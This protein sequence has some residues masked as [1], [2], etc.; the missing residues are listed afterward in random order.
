MDALRAI[1]RLHARFPNVTGIEFDVDVKAL[2][3]DETP[4]EPDAL[5][6]E[7]ICTD[8]CFLALTELDLSKAYNLSFPSIL[9]LVQCS[10]LESLW[11]PQ[12]SGWSEDELR[13]LQRLPHLRH[14]TTGDRARA[15]PTYVEAVACLTNLTSFTWRCDDEFVDVQELTPAPALSRLTRLRS[16]NV[17]APVQVR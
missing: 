4:A 9:A 1:P 7:F 3:S 5:F 16:L 17:E 13:P 11:L 10:R 14:L 12:I 8:A 15:T 2:Q 6:C